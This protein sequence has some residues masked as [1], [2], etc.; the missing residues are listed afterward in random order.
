MTI[1][2]ARLEEELAEEKTVQAR[3]QAELVVVQGKLDQHDPEAIAQIRN[4]ALF[5]WHESSFKSELERYKERVAQLERDLAKTSRDEPVIVEQ[6]V[7]RSPQTS[8]ELR[9][10]IDTK[11]RSP[12]SNLSSSPPTLA[13]PPISRRLR[14]NI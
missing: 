6:C 13:P 9:H 1:Q 11:R 8:Q 3:L 4:A 10:H 7:F 5:S 14:Q 2:F 12:L